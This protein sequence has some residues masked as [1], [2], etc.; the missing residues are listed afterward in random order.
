MYTQT[1]SCGAY[2]FRIVACPFDEQVMHRS[3]VENVRVEWYSCRFS[4]MGQMIVHASCE[5][6]SNDV[7][8]DNVAVPGVHESTR[9]GMLSYGAAE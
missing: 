1:T 6:S 8:L 3:A 5:S 4:F 2:P 7:S 9:A